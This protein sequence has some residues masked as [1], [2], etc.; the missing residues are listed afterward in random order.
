MLC[1]NVLVLLMTHKVHAFKSRYLATP[2][3]EDASVHNYKHETK[4]TQ[5][6]FIKIVI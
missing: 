3:R 5:L 1:S 6:S 2:D 4:N